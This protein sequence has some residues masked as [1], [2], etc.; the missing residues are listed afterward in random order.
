[1][2]S[3]M[4]NILY[5]FSD[6]FTSIYLIGIISN[7]EHELIA[8]DFG[9]IMWMISSIFA[10]LMDCTVI[11]CFQIKKKK[12]INSNKF[13]YLVLELIKDVLDTMM[14]MF[15]VVFIGISKKNMGMLGIATSVIRLSKFAR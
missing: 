13:H 10:V 15:Y 6:H 2:L 5:Y 8:D 14:A 1:M 11:V 12:S 9:N 3:M 4:F 7:K